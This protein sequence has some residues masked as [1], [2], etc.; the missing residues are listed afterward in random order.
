[1]SP[2]L[3]VIMLGVFALVFRSDWKRRRMRL[4]GGS[5]RGEKARAEN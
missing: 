3:I 4:Q 2:V 1:M 5:G